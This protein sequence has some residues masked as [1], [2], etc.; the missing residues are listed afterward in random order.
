MAVITV[1]TDGETV[2]VGNG[3]TVII[4]IPGGGTVNIVAEPGATIKTFRIE[5]GGDDEADTVVIDLST[6]SDYDLH[7]DIK[8]YDP[9]DAVVLEDAFGT[10]VESGNEDEYQ[11]S[12]VGD[13]GVTYNGFLRAK[14]KGEKDFTSDPPPIIICFAAGTVID[15]DLGP[16]PIESLAVGDLVRTRDHD[17]Q[18]I[19][20]IGRR[21]LDTL[22]LARLPQLR[23]VRFA[24]GALGRN[25]PFKDLEVSPQH[26]MVLSGWRAEISFGEPEV[27]V[28]A[29]G[30]VNDRDVT[31]VADASSV[32]YFHLLFDEHEIITANGVAAESLHAG[33]MAMAAL[34]DE[35][36][37]ELAAIFPD[38]PRQLGTR[39]TA[40]PVC[41]KYEAIAALAS[42]A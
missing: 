16:T 31:I 24:Q 22:D 8:D 18:P 15:T 34:S 19:R 36:L 4:D 5:F 42:A 20:W 10:Y 1:T 3:D 17:L 13:D 39:L 37:T 40:R 2:V 14:D 27:L 33:E 28:P 26:R 25:L 41:K 6:F 23:P 32:T 38:A 30:F 35:S 29:L 21:R 12:Y 7:I 11:Y 9:N